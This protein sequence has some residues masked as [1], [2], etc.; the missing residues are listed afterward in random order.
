MRRALL[1]L[2]L[3]GVG[4]GAKQKPP[5]PTDD[6]E[7]DSFMDHTTEAHPEAQPPPVDDADA[8]IAD[9]KIAV[10]EDTPPPDGPRIDLAVRDADVADVMRMIAA[11]A[12][13]SIVVSDDVDAKVT[14]EVRRVTWRQAIDVIAQLEGLDVSEDDGIVTVT[15]TP[16]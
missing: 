2:V 15:R 3:A 5:A 6:L 12:K 1:W 11:A 16:R 14:L 9:V 8:G 7:L 10:V 4:C 13:I